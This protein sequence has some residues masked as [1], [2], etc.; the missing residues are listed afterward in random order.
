LQENR[1]ETMRLKL[2]H[3]YANMTGM[4]RTW[5]EEL[6][7]FAVKNKQGYMLFSMSKLDLE[8]VEILL[9]EQAG[10]EKAEQKQNL[11]TIVSQVDSQGAKL[12]LEKT[13]QSINT[14]AKQ[15]LLIKTVPSKDVEQKVL[16]EKNSTLKISYL[17]NPHITKETSRTVYDTLEDKHELGAGFNRF[18]SEKQ[19]LKAIN[20]VREQIRVAEEKSQVF[21]LI[22]GTYPT[23]CRKLL[24]EELEEGNNVRNK[25]SKDVLV[26]LLKHTP[27]KHFETVILWRRSDEFFL[28]SY[29]VRDA[30]LHNLSMTPKV[31]EL[32]NETG[33]EYSAAL[34]RLE[35]SRKHVSLTDITNMSDKHELKKLGELVCSPRHLYSHV[36]TMMVLHRAERANFTT[37]LGSIEKTIREKTPRE[38]NSLILNQSLAVNPRKTSKTPVD[39]LQKELQYI[40]ENL[41]NKTEIQTALK[42]LSEHDSKAEMLVDF[43]RHT[44]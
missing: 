30:L 38:L 34:N 35:D 17:A 21:S 20:S 39:W 31:A 11:E 9:K 16:K 8:T 6:V 36:Y 19:V 22:G 37:R 41:S 15:Q 29:Q 10:K 2:L 12:L 5:R 25:L 24:F 42:L 40:Q 18:L 32:L 28:H 43:V 33:A 13:W 44:R 1:A 14:D 7:K 3:L 4:N 23:F 27:L 26:N